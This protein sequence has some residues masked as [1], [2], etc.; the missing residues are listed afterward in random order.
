MRPSRNGI[1]SSF[2]GHQP[3]ELLQGFLGFPIVTSAITIVYNFWLPL[4]FFCLFWQA[5]GERTTVTRIQFLLAF[6]FTWAIAGNLLAVLLSSAGPC[7]YGRL[8]IMPDVYAAQMDYLRAAAAEY[9][10]WSMRVQ[11]LLWQS[12]VTGD[13]SINGI[14]AMPSVHVT[15]AT[16]MTFLGW[17]TSRAAGIG[18]TL[19]TIVIVIGS[20]HLAWHYAVDSIA[21]IVLGTIFWLAAGIIARYWLSRE[22]REVTQP[23]RGLSA[24]RPG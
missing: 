16:V 6:A 3:W 17:R 13:G 22:P 19:F 11:D 20:V 4:I 23:L 18:F 1:A 12:Y 5:F 10:V 9:P 8:G 15:A 21:G 2:F 7:F 24:S 14:S